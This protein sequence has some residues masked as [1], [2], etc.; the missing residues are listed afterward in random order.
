LSRLKGFPLDAL[1]IDGSFVRDI[2]TDAND[3]AITRAII[4]M[5]HSLELA[6]V[7]EGVETEEQLMFLDANGCDQIQGY[8]FS[9]PLPAEECT[10]F[11]ASGRR[12]LL[13]VRGA[14]AEPL[15]LAAE[16]PLRRA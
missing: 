5:A 6:V 16:I 4:T 11:I 7:A 10:A 13:P 12:L 14:L 1:K 2:T 8:Y 3:A 15:A 9:T